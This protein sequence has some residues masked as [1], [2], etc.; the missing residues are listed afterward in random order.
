[1]TVKCSNDGSTLGSG[2]AL[3]FYVTPTTTLS[4][5]TGKATT[6]AAYEYAYFVFT[7]STTGS[8]TF[9]STGSTDTYGYL[10]NTSAAQ[11]RS[12]DDGGASY[13]FSITYEL[14]AGQKY[15]LGVR[16]YGSRSGSFYVYVTK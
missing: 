16:C 13:N 5:N 2:V 9:Y 4:L 14:T 6:L 15:V 11:L 3:T 7:P 8:Y 10:Y 12:N 1:M